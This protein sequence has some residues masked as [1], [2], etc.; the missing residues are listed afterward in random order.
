MK[1]KKWLLIAGVAVLG[2][3]L[4]GTGAV[5]K[6]AAYAQQKVKTW[7]DDNADPKEEIERLKAQLKDLDKTE[8]DIKNALAKD[9]NQSNKLAK[10]TEDLRAAIAKEDEAA[11]AFAKAIQDTQGNKVSLGKLVM[12]VDDAKRKLIAD[13]DAITARSASLKTMAS[14]HGSI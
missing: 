3:G 11:R 2:V 13:T 10:Q 8:G 5:K 4:V 7:V 12:S 6:Y 9:I 1:L 14:V